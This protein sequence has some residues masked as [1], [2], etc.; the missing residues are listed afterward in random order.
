[1]TSEVADQKV[2]DEEFWKDLPTMT[3]YFSPAVSTLQKHL[4]VGTKEIMYL[5][6]EFLGQKASSLEPE[7]SPLAMLNGFVSVW[8]EYD[9]GTLRI[10][11]TA[12]LTL[13]ISDCRIC[14]Q[15]PG[16]GDMFECAFHEGFFRGA[17]STKLG[18]PVGFRQEG[19]Y[20]GTSGTWCRR[21]VSDTNI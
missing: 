11:S 1:M 9:I 3:D 14:G 20:E 12:P 5:L 2:P 10:E 21:L 6:G 4:G 18:K 19:N 17:L 8:N 15:L 13:V 7:S 16:T